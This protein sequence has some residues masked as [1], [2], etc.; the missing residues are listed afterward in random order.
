MADNNQGN[1]DKNKI[2]K[3]INFKRIIFVSALAI[4]TTILLAGSSY[5][6]KLIDNKEDSSNKKNGPAAVRNYTNT[7]KIDEDGNISFDQSVRDLWDELKKNNNTITKY[8]DSPEELAKLINVENVTKFPYLGKDP[9]KAKIDTKL[10]SQSVDINTIQGIIKFKRATVDS[11]GKSTEKYLE[12]I[13]ESELQKLV[14]KYNSTGDAKDREKAMSYFTVKEN[15]NR[16][17]SYVNSPYSHWPT[18]SCTAISQ[19]YKPGHGA[20]DIAALMG[21]NVEAVEAGKVIN[22]VTGKVRIFENPNS[23]ETNGNYVAIDHGNGKITLYN[24]L[25]DVTVTVGEIV[26]KGQLIGHV[27]NTGYTVGETGEHLHFAVFN[28]SGTINYNNFAL[29]NDPLKDFKYDNGMGEGDYGIGSAYGGG[30]SSSEDTETEN[31]TESE[32]RSE[33]ETATPTP[34]TE[35]TPETQT[36]GITGNWDPTD[37]KIGENPSGAGTFL[38]ATGGSGS[39]YTVNIYMRQQVAEVLQNGTHLKTILVSTAENPARAYG[40]YGDGTHRKTC[41]M[42]RRI[43]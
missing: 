28:G 31:E 27:G 30:T 19:Y 41:V 12:Y 29:R 23:I 5:I 4:A 15:K 35:T 21:D 24:H 37:P 2:K 33:T 6:L 20:I 8:L 9:E 10:F 25:Q 7:A 38:G 16:K 1:T 32:P 34:T 40:W 17:G 43:T 18:P 36:T 42:N 14:D 11:S 22:A 13:S 39:G 26:E 3:I